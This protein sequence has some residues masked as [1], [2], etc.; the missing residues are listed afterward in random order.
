MNLKLNLA[1]LAIG[2]AICSLTLD[3]MACST[4]IVGKNAS[5]TGNIIVG[6]NEDNGGRILTAQYWVPP[7]THKPGEMVKFEEAAASIPQVEKTYGFW[8]SQTLD[9]AGASFS[10]GFVNENGVTIVSNACSGIYK[11]DIMPTK[12]GGIG[13]GI[14]RLMAERATSARNAVDIAIDLLTKYGYFDEGRTYTIADP[15]E[16]WQ[17]AI[18][19]GNTWVARRVQDDEVVYI[20]N[21]FMMDKVDATDTKNFIVAPGMIERAIKN[22]R[23]KPA[24][25]GVYKDFNYRVAVAPAERRSAEYNRTRNNLAWNKIIGK[26]ITDPEKFPYSGKPTKKWT[27]A[28]VQDLLRTHEHGIQ[29]ED[30]Q[31]TH[32]KSIGICRASTHESEVFEMNENPLLIVGYRVLA[33]PCESPYIPFFPLARPAEGTSFMNWQTATAEQ[34]KGTTENFSYRPD[35][36]VST[37]V[38]A[39]N[40]YDFQR[41][42]QKDVRSFVEKLE[43]KWMKD[44]PGVMEHAKTLLK[45]SD[46]K[47]V[48]YLHSYNVRMLNEAQAEVADELAEKAPWKMTVMAD[49]IDPKSDKT[50]E[51]VLFSSKKLDATKADPKQ[52][53]GG[54][55]R[56]SIGN[57]VK[58]AE[59][60]AQP[61]KSEVRDVDGDGRKD[62]VF[63]FTQ[64][65]LSQNMLAGAYYDIWLHTYVNGKRVAAMD[66]A[67]I[68]SEGHKGPYKR[69]QRADL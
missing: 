10:D 19:Q 28:D 56:A 5:A 37:F 20:P 38:K 9:P 44:V 34:F 31:W 58:M 39:A 43:A 63:T 24:V 61:V 53:W 14:R 45:V 30:K 23:Y 29:D 8:W 2:A 50:V 33:R 16:A 65:G 67:W 66:A 40:T 62:M 22:G 18:H 52:T 49:A 15:H 41:Q 55:G 13:Y 6:H 3:A 11:D 12:D 27:V 32:T 26:N 60:L 68:E 1:A 64:K 69:T 25:P 57:G 47:A 51:V 54:V 7:A 48:E 21:N 4:V 59:K 46:G 36:P 35:W 42:D 17:L